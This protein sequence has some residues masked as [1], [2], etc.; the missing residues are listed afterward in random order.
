MRLADKVAVITGS[1]SGIGLATADR[2]RLEGAQVLG[3]DLT[4]EAPCDVSSAS[5]VEAAAERVRRVDVLV[6]AAGISPFGRTLDIP[7]EDFER[8]WRIN[9]LGAVHV[10][11]SFAPL[12]PDGASIVLVS[13]INAITGA[14]GL[15]A[16]AAAKGALLTFGRTLALELAD[17]RIRVNTVCPA[18]VDTP[19]LQS[20]FDRQPDPAAARARNILRHPLGRLGTAEDVANMI[21]FLAS[22]ESS[23]ITGGTHLVDGGALINR[24]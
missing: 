16:Y 3:L 11:K 24:S 6:H 22:D 14:P 8:V 9:F 10:V 17:R 4:A 20:S 5:D 13:S 7:V 2:F 23:W 19:M 1:A 21:L 18:S 15:A 12:M